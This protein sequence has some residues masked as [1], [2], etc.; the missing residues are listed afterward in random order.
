VSRTPLL[1]LV[2]LV[3]CG[4]KEQPKA[5]SAPD[6]GEAATTP[7][8]WDE[9]APVGEKVD[10][11]AGLIEKGTPDSLQTAI[12]MLEPL[13]DDDPSGTARF[14]LGV[15][16]HKSGNFPKATNQYQALVAGDPTFGDAWLYL[17]KAQEQQG[18]LEA[19]I[20]SFE[21]GIRNAPEHMELRAALVGTL[22]QAGRLD[23]A[24]ER[25]KE[26]L[27]VNANHL[28]IYNN[29]GLAYLE[30]GDQVLA[31]FIFTKALQQ[32]EGADDNAWLHTNIGWSYY[33]D[34]NT[35]AAAQELEKAV[36]LDPELVP[37]LVY[38]SRV[39]MDDRNYVDTVPLL[40]TAARL[41]PNNADV[42][43][44]LGVA[45]RGVGRLDDAQRAYEKAL[46]LDPSDPA[47]RF[48]LGILLGDYRKDYDGAVA[49]F[50]EYVAAGGQHS[51]Q[52][53]AYIDDI[54]KEKERALKRATAEAE[55]KAREAERKRKEA[56][57][58]EAEA[59]PVPAEPPTAEPTPAEPSP[60]PPPEEGQP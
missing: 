12:R 45:Y 14:N 9:K 20:T 56:L 31:R 60:E 34:G 42:Q 28:G 8:T 6:G 52:A 53:T 33:L 21:T 19:A 16:Y 49:Q 22:R 4:P 37:A 59:Q 26:A 47:P 51:A 1:A 57:V 24:I 27:E 38:L 10:Q 32:I 44:T 43:L 54:R 2:L 36:K 41:D 46:V 40:E 55:R 3:G 7:V 5:A 30:K 50:Q 29:F 48:N 15:A 17:G 13:T 39:Y 11:A 18:E 25:S 58:Q 35:P 23:E